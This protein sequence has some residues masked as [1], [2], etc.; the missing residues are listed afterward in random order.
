MARNVGDL[1]LL[2][3]VL[4][5]PDPRAP[6][7]LGDPGASF[8]PPLTPAPL[9]GL[10]VACSVDLGGAFEVDHEVADV[11]RATAARLSDAGAAVAEAHPDLS[12]ADDTFRTLRAWHF[13][14][15]LGPAARR[16]PD[17]VQ[18]VARGQ[19]P[20]RRAADRR[21]RGPRPTRSAPRCRRRCGSSSA[22]TTCC[23]CRPPR[24]RRS[25]SS[26]SSPRRSTGRRCPTTSPGCARPTSSP[27]P[28]ARRSPSRPARTAD[29]LP[30]GVQLVARHGADRQLLEVAAAVEELLAH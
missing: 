21:R 3:S 25:R 30:V 13:Q 15:K 19:H 17:V 6:L 20:R 14:A 24:C 12:L 4:A 11:V 10:R 5:G 16:A 7:A 1:A 22:S 27:S 28:G 23:C 2:L 18:A 8:A 26:R 9:A 29:G